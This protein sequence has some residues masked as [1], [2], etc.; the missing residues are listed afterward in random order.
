MEL[1]I[2]LIIGGLYL[3]TFILLA[4][5]AKKMKWW[6]TGVIL[7]VFA[8]IMGIIIV[9][10]LIM[11]PCYL[12]SSSDCGLGA[13]FMIMYNGFIALIV[14]FSGIFALLFRNYKKHYPKK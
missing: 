5:N 8:L 6:T 11:L 13:A 12:S 14:F 9:P 2:L 7:M 10:F 1:F 4:K 3:T